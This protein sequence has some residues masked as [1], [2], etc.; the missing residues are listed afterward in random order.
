MG[1]SHFVQQAEVSECH[2][3]KMEVSKIL[4]KVKGRKVLDVRIMV[5][6]TF[7]CHLRNRLLPRRLPHVLRQLCLT[8][9]LPTLL[10]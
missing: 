3:L 7:L 2:E 5:L 6:K 8:E 9:M 4:T 10:P 1:G